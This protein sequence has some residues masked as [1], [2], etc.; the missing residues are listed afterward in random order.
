MATLKL[1]LHL[2]KE[3]AGDPESVAWEVQ[4]RIVCDVP[5][6]C[7]SSGRGFVSKVAPSILNIT[8]S[9]SKRKYEGKQPSECT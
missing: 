7:S 8:G 9:L 3:I 5:K 1:L 2:A 6:R 4:G